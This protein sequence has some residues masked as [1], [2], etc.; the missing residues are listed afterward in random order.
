MAVLR[1]GRAHYPRESVRAGFRAALGRSDRL[2][3]IASAS[4]DRRRVACCG[5]TTIRGIALRV[6]AAAL[7]VLTEPTFFDGSLGT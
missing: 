2:N 7:S 5:P 1:P 3:V 4:A 6:A